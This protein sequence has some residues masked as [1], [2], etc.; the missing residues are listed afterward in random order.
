MED[1][2]GR[3]MATVAQRAESLTRAS[4]ALVELVDGADMVFVAATGSVAA[5]LGERYP[6]AG[7]LTGLCIECGEVLSCDDAEKDPR[8]NAQAARHLGVGSMV[9][10]PLIVHERAVGVLEVVSKRPHAFDARA[11]E[12]LRLLTGAIAPRLGRARHDPLTG[13]GNPRE[14]DERLVREVARAGRHGGTVTVMLVAVADGAPDDVLRFVGAC[15]RDLRGAEAAYRAGPW[16]FALVLPDTDAAAAARLAWRL[17]ETLSIDGR[18]A[19]EWSV[20]ELEPGLSAAA[21]LARAAAQVG[22]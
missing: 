7:S 22:A 9:C 10:A 3:A 4:G 2:A 18:I 13:L 16:E 19:V 20:A 14:L 1:D 17:D 11:G 21:L 8:V 12:T 5:H 6:L 15:L